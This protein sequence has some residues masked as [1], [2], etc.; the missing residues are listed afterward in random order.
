MKTTP[1]GVEMAAGQGVGGG[2]YAESE[3]YIITPPP[4]PHPTPHLPKFVVLDCFDWQR[5]RLLSLPPPPPL[6]FVFTS[7]RFTVCLSYTHCQFS[8]WVNPFCCRGWVVVVRFCFTSLGRFSVD[9]LF[10]LCMP[11]IPLPKN[12]NLKQCRN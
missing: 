1:F 12:H 9:Y 8:F 11:L 3:F 5:E 10:A 6:S 7:L 4:P 2:E